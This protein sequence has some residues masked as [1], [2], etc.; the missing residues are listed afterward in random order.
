MFVNLKAFKGALDRLP[1]ENLPDD[2]IILYDVNGFSLKSSSWGAHDLRSTPLLSELNR[3]VNHNE[4]LT[5][6]EIAGHLKMSRNTIYSF[7]RKEGKNSPQMPYIET[8]K[9]IR[10]LSSDYLAFLETCYQT[11]K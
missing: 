4:M 1:L 9:G 2:T 7:L 8:E 5:V 6:S 10:V 3:M 11:R